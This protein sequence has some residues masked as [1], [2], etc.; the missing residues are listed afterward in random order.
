MLLF[1]PDPKPLTEIQ[2]GESFSVLV[3]E[4]DWKRGVRNQG[5]RCAVAHALKRAH[6]VNALVGPAVMYLRRDDEPNWRGDSPINHDGCGLIVAFD[7]GESFPGP[8]V[9][10]FTRE[11]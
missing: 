3:T 5:D 11:R 9:V 6:S 1:R 4:E 2:V 8:T 7:L 10:T